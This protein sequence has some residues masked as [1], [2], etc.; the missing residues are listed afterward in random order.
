MFMQLRVGGG[1]QDI[2]LMA[3]NDQMRNF[4]TGQG[5]FFTK[6]LH[7]WEVYTSI[8]VKVNF[9]LKPCTGGKF[10]LPTCPRFY[11]LDLCGSIYFHTGQGFVVNKTLTCVEV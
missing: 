4:H 1:C 11:N 6:T 2:M 10:I 3:V 8:Q 7:R 9:S 5:Y